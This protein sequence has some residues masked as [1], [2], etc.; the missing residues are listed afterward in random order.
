MVQCFTSIRAEMIASEKTSAAVSKRVPRGAKDE[1]TDRY[2]PVSWRISKSL[3]ISVSLSRLF[4]ISTMQSAMR[5]M[6]ESGV[7]VMR[8]IFPPISRAVS[9]ASTTDRVSP[10]PE[11]ATRTSPGPN[12]GVIVS[13]MT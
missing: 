9:H 1:D 7:D 12:A 13:P 6:C 10:E 8:Q 5:P 11:N 2:C 3:G 4:P